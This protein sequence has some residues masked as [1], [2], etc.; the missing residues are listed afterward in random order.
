MVVYTLLLRVLT[1]RLRG[2]DNGEMFVIPGGMFV[3]PAEAGIQLLLCNDH[4]KYSS[5]RIL[6]SHVKLF[7]YF[8]YLLLKKISECFG[9][10]QLNKFPDIILHGLLNLKSEFIGTVV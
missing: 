7:N 5:L 10:C 4:K 1:S 3:I 2:S 8:V 6:K 9:C